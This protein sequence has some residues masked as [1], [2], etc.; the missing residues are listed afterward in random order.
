MIFSPAFLKLLLCFHFL[1]AELRRH[2]K[3]NER[4]LKWH[5]IS[6][7]GRLALIK[8]SN[9]RRL[10]K[11]VLCVAS[12]RGI[13]TVR[14]SLARPGW[15]RSEM[16]RWN[17]TSCFLSSGHCN[18]IFSV[19]LWVA[20]QLTSWSVAPV[21]HHVGHHDVHFIFLFSCGSWWGRALISVHSGVVPNYKVGNFLTVSATMGCII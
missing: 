21:G 18:P 7:T 16:N 1:Q 14:I 5:S 19:S 12:I 17:P 2:L 4:K 15:K 13:K 20:N 6:P 10:D 11:V 3:A 8:W 9:W